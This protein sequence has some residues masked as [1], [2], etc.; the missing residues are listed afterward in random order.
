MKKTIFTA[1]ILVV[2]AFSISLHAWAASET[3]AASAAQK[4]YAMYGVAFYNLENLF[5][6]I[7]D[8]GKRD[9]EY[10]PNGRNKWCKMKYEAKLHNLARVLS[11]LCTD[12][13]PAGP[14]VI[15]LAE[16]ENTRVLDDLLKQPALV[17]RGYQYVD[18]G[19]LDRRGIECAFFYNPRMFQ[20]ERSYLVPFYYGMTGEIEDPLLGFYT[21]DKGKVQAYDELKGDTTYITRGF[22]VMEGKLAGE[23]M[24][25]IVNHWPSR[26]AGD[27]V[28]QRAGFQVRQL[29]DAILKQTPGI[30]IMVM[31][32]MND[33]PGNNSMV[34]Q[35]GCVSKVKEAKT[36]RDMYNPWYNTLYKVGQGTLMY[37]GKWNLFDQIVMSGNMV[38]KDYSDLKYYQHAIFLRDYLFQQEGKFRGSPLRTHAGGVWLNG[39]SDHLPTQIY[40]LKEK[41]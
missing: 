32:D 37:K 5:D 22:L 8:A 1:V 6:T 25:F 36:A 3:S 15:G 26:A 18:H 27:E 20:L 7:H 4:K 33:D 10:L 28:R 19:S 23:D 17:K 9:H 41:K 14:A 16:V 29:M 2:A 34:K 31:G 40:L 21:D 12:K 39:Y 30:K 35:L 24:A 13:L 11:E 38:G